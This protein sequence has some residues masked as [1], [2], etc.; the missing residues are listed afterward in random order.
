MLYMSIHLKF[1]TVIAY[2]RYK[3][4]QVGCA[5]TMVIKTL[6]LNPSIGSAVAQWWSA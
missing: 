6:T 4:V 5:Y 1:H 2:D 3:T